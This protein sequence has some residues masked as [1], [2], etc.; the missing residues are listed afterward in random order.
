ML[1]CTEA[2]DKP[3]RKVS[4]HSAFITYGTKCIP[5]EWIERIKEFVPHGR[6]MNLIQA[7]KAQVPAKLLEQ[8]KADV[9]PLLEVV[10]ADPTRVKGE[11]SKLV[12]LLCKRDTEKKVKVHPAFKALYVCPL[13]LGCMRGSSDQ[14]RW[15]CGLF[16]PPITMRHPIDDCVWC[17]RPMNAVPDQQCPIVC[18]TFEVA[19]WGAFPLA[20]LFF[21]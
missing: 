5:A 7:Y 6:S 8:F 15:P 3:A 13:P 11:S 4:S 14:Q 10:N 2:S 20:Q 1:S 17:C 19:L 9:E 21:C 16:D 18:I 12:E